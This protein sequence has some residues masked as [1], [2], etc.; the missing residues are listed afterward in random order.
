MSLSSR[1]YVDPSSSILFSM[2]RFISQSGV[3]M[4]ILLYEK[5][6]SRRNGLETA[7]FAHDS[8]KPIVVP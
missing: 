3:K 1:N 6:G 7:G 8:D 4:L 5:S 2:N